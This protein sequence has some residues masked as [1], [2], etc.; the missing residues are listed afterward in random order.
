MDYYKIKKY[1]KDNKDAKA[2]FELF[3]NA[4]GRG[5]YI[6]SW[7]SMVPIPELKDLEDLDASLEKIQ[8]QESHKMTC[9]PVFDKKTDVPE[10]L[11]VVGSLVLIAK[12]LCMF[13]GNKW[14]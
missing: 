12:K 6:K 11:E 1:L 10:E 8:D 4:D 14:I 3:D 2:H 9:I 13:D 7:E 5:C